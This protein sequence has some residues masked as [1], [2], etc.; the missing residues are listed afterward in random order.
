MSDQ[1]LIAADAMCAD[2]CGDADDADPPTRL[3]TSTPGSAN[4]PGAS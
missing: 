2:L 4:V 3:R 1:R